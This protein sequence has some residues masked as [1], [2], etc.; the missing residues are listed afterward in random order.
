MYIWGRQVHRKM[1]QGR[2]RSQKEEGGWRP[3]MT[4]NGCVSSGSQ[5]LDL[6]Y[7]VTCVSVLLTDDRP[8]TTKTS[9]GNNRQGA[10]GKRVDGGDEKEREIDPC[11]K[12]I[13]GHGRGEDAA[14]MLVWW[15]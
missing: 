14:A 2:F 12:C 15:W 6:R 13:E 11:R 7:Q 4:S 10:W 8:R 9:L 1:K 3:R 5:W